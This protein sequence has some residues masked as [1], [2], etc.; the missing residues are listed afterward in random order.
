MSIRLF[1]IV[2]T[3]FVALLFT[4]YMSIKIIAAERKE[5]ERLSAIVENLKLNMS[6]VITYSK[7]I[8]KIKTTGNQFYQKLE[9]A[10]TNEE[11]NNIVHELISNNNKLVQDTTRS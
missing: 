2:A 5:N 7:N 3:V 9:Q 1:M 10:K 6:Q 8:E 4:I 11:I